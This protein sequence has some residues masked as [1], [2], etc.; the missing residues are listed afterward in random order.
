MSTGIFHAPPT[1]QQTAENEK[2]KNH[3]AEYLKN[4]TGGYLIDSGYLPVSRCGISTHE[5]TKNPTRYQIGQNQFNMTP[6]KRCFPAAYIEDHEWKV[7]E[8]GAVTVLGEATP[9][10][11]AR[12]WRERGF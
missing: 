8:N 6:C 5:A 11:E 12:Y 1:P 3:N 4:R 9:E 7:E 10:D 2:V